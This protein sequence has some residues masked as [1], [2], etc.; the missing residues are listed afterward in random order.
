MVVSK[1][2]VQRDPGVS[3]FSLMVKLLSALNVSEKSKMDE[4]QG[5]HEICSVRQTLVRG[6]EPE[7]GA[8]MRQ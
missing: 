1:V 5:C 2:T 3:L 7:G 8:A 4:F 6:T